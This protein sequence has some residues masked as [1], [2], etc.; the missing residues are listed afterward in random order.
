MHPAQK[1]HYDSP[2]VDRKAWKLEKNL[3]KFEINLYKCTKIYT[4]YEEGA[5]WLVE[6]YFL[7]D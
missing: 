3:L 1:A 4:L 2:S 7:Q 5:I 6:G